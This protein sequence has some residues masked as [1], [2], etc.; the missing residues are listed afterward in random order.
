MVDND[1]FVQ[2]SS[3]NS[4]IW[5][6]E[7][8]NSDVRQALLKIAD[9]FFNDLELE[10]VQID[11][12]T[13][14]GSLANFNYTK[15]SDID[16]HLLVDYS[17]VDEDT[18]LVG[19]Y[20]R[21]KT[22]LWNQNHKIMIRGYEVE[23]YVQD[24]NEEHHSTGVFSLQNDSWIK[25]PGQKPQNYDKSV[26]NKKVESFADQIERAQDLYDDKKYKEANKFAEKLMKKIKKFRQS[27]LE[28][29]GEYSNENLV[30]KILRNEEHIRDLRDVRTSSY[31][32]MMSLDG[33]Y[34]KK[35]KIYLE[36]D[37]SKPPKGFDRV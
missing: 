23:I 37:D 24:T 29:G 9:N 25:K 5:A 36:E 34:K 26:V 16:L 6:A 12:I 1:V 27:G 31:D 11:D 20:F 30:F 18:K 3:L 22:A 28:T 8:L 7:S 21:A 19:E 2:K 15:F 33:D 17:K 14:T 13:F 10:G 32:K 35:F 4:K